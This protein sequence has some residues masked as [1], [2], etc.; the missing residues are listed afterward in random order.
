MKALLAE[1]EGWLKAPASAGQSKGAAVA[2]TK[3]SKTETPEK[4]S[5]DAT[6]D[7]SGDYAVLPTTGVDEVFAAREA[8]GKGPP[9]KTVEAPLATGAYS[10]L[11]ADKLAVP[12]GFDGEPTV[13]ALE[14]TPPAQLTPVPQGQIDDAM[15][16]LLSE[17]ESWGTEPSSGTAT[18]AD[19]PAAAT[20]A[21]TAASGASTASEGAGY[22]VL[23]TTSVDAVF[24][25]R[26]A[27]GQGSAAK[28]VEAPLAAGA[29]SPLPQAKMDVPKGF[30]GEPTVHALEQTPPAQLTPVPQGQIDDAMKSLLAEREGW[31]TEPAAGGAGSGQDAPAKSAAQTATATQTAEKPAPDG[32]GRSA[33]AADCEAKLRKAAEGGVIRFASA[34]VTIDSGSNA[35][36]D[37][38]A[39]V[40]MSCKKGRIRVEGHTDSTGRAAFNKTLSEKRAQSVVDYLSKAGVDA[41]RIEAVGYGQEKPIA[42]NNT[43]EGRAKNRRIEFTVVE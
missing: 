36:L 10:P 42:S 16:A 27:W 3:A 24:T 30:D 9:P 12:K 19:A 15:K 40:A 28:E 2:E 21:D 31:G 1:R 38:L 41:S 20:S 37:T 6:S 34:S 33:E 25:A 17:R 39:E 18:A 7:G 32:A 14:Q 5:S 22:P 35:T 11:P 29:V 13:H 43:R 26:E 23:P 4:S 8:W